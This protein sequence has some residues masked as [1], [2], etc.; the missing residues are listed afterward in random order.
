MPPAEQHGQKRRSTAKW[1]VVVSL[2]WTV[3]MG[4][5]NALGHVQTIQEA[6]ADWSNYVAFVTAIL[7]WPFTGPVVAMLSL[8]AFFYYDRRTHHL[9]GQGSDELALDIEHHVSSEQAVL[10]VRNVG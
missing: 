7:L 8:I 10:C 3:L 6:I 1:V 4:T 5:L 9:Y 2:L